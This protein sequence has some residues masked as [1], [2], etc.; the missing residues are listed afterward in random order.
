M[1]HCL[2]GHY[3]IFCF[4]RIVTVI[5]RAIICNALYHAVYPFNMAGAVLVEV[6]VAVSMSQEGVVPMAFWGAVV[7]MVSADDFHIYYIPDLVVE[8]QKT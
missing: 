2:R 5:Q 1:T 6:G 3:S 8:K 7:P 4:F